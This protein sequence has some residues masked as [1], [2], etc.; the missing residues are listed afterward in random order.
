MHHS[1]YHH[2]FWWPL[3]FCGAFVVKVRRSASSEL[4]RP[5]PINSIDIVIQNI[6]M[7]CLQV[8]IYKNKN[9]YYCTSA[10]LWWQACGLQPTSCLTGLAGQRTNV[11]RASFMAM[12]IWLCT[13]ILWQSLSIAITFEKCQDRLRST[14]K[15][16]MVPQYLS[17]L[18]Q[19]VP[20]TNWSS[21]F[22]KLRWLILS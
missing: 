6:D 9:V 8:S 18:P 7:L 13:G 20:A 5:L 1:L 21:T 14:F 3:C 11:S 12:P 15:M 2:K 10:V 17:T 22:K 4:K 16:Q 19:L